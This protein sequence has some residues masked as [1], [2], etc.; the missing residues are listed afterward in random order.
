VDLDDLSRA[1]AKDAALM[2]ALTREF[3]EELHEVLVL[4][5]A[6]I[7]RLLRALE[8]DTTGRVVATRQNL[9]RAVALRQDLL[10]VLERAGYHDLVARATDEP[11]DRLTR[12]VLQS[13]PKLLT[14]YD[15]DALVALKE[16]R[17]A[18][19]LQIG[20]E[21]G[22]QMWR[23]VVDGVL[24]IRDLGHLVDDVADMLDVSDKIARQVYDTAISSFSRQVALLGATGEPTEEFVYVGPNDHRTRPFCAGLIGD[25]Y[26]REA[27]DKMDNGQLP[28]VMLTGGGWNCRHQWRRITSLDRETLRGQG[29]GA[30]I[31]VDDGEQDAE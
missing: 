22:V 24:G 15:L 16:I 5:R 29:R 12:Q 1:V 14:T 8:T 26:E 27:I 31:D 11:L 6:Q 23:V 20:E 3:A 4:T 9:Q 17:F 19:L 2:D 21:A 18:E 7:R 25:V 30:L 10:S 13:A 28:N